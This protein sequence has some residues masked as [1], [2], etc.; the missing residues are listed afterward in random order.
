MFGM[1]LNS[2]TGYCSVSEICGSVI[3]N[4][5]ITIGR[6][7]FENDKTL[8]SITIPEGAIVIDERAFKGCI[9]LVNINLPQSLQRIGSRAF[10]GCVNLSGISLPDGVLIDEGA[11]D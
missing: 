5:V 8:R 10:S 3:P 2:A 11:F 1:D 7:V 6:R 9:N 4:G